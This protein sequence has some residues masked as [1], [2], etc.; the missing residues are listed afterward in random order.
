MFVVIYAITTAMLMSCSADYKPEFNTSSNLTVYDTQ[1]MSDIAQ[2][3][4]SSN[5]WSNPWKKI[6]RTFSG[7]TDT[8]PFGNP[9][10]QGNGRCG[11][12]PSLCLSVSF[13]INGD[14]ASDEI[15][16]EDY[17][18]GYRLIE[19]NVIN[20]TLNNN[21]YLM[22]KVKSDYIQDYLMDDYLTIPDSHTI[23]TTIS[24]D[25]GFSAMTIEPGCYK[26]T[27]I[28]GDAY[29]VLMNSILTI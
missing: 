5:G 12:C 7:K 22:V 2:A 29:I 6:V 9:N 1:E 26:A 13:S 21:Q 27:Y 16:Q 17:D 4:Y 11:T 20:N 19:L 10:C 18:A 8:N 25:A 14:G 24:N 15:S 28:N 23:N 3:V